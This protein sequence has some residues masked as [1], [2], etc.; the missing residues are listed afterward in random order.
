MTVLMSA[1]AFF[2]I[3]IL[4]GV[5]LKIPAMESGATTFGVGMGAAFIAFLIGSLIG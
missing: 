5:V 2:G 3:G 4:K 1:I